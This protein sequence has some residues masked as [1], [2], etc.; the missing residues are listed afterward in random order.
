MPQGKENKLKYLFCATKWIC[1]L[2]STFSSFSPTLRSYL[3]WFFDFSDR[4]HEANKDIKQNVNVAENKSFAE[5]EQQQQQA[6]QGDNNATEQIANSDTNEVRDTIDNNSIKQ[7]ETKLSH[8][9][10]DYQLKKQKVRIAF[11]KNNPN[12]GFVTK[13]FFVNEFCFRKCVSLNRKRRN[14]TEYIDPYMY[15]V[16]LF[17]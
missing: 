12:Y 6:R 3:C 4:E 15:V 5:Y 1:A 13:L 2:S 16:V 17:A 14:P 10:E 9:D 7:R 8:D 11:M